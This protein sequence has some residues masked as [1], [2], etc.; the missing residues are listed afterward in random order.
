MDSFGINW[1]SDTSDGKTLCLVV[2]ASVPPAL[3]ETEGSALLGRFSKQA[4]KP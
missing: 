4:S 2:A 1:F 3:W